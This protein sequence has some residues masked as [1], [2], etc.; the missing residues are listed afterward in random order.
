M[1][2]GRLS[3]N[4][5]TAAR[6]PGLPL[7]P[8]LLLALFTI[9][10]IVLAIEPKYRHDWALENVLVLPVVAILVLSGRRFPFSNLSYTLIFV[11]LCLHEIGA[12][13]TYAEVP[14]DDWFKSWTGRSLND[15]LGWQRNN[16]DRV[17]HFG[18]GCLLTIPIR[19]LTLRITGRG[20]F[21][22][23]LVPLSLVMSS[24]MLFEVVEWFAAL[25]FGGDLGMAYLGTQGDVWDAH[26][27]MA[28]ASLG[29]MMVLAPLEIRSRWAE[30]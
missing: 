26:K 18:Y 27:D 2:A 12:H 5:E 14:Y 25:V 8:G 24:S 29:A 28:L 17:I 23:W 4:R 20:N 16:F 6:R 19:E 13:F 30:P 21:W 7:Y 22:T 10:W 3:P 15:L 11:F 9:E 1:T